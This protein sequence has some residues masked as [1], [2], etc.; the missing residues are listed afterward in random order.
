[1]EDLQAKMFLNRNMVTFEPFLLRKKT[2]MISFT[3]SE[4]K[5]TSRINWDRH[6]VFETR[7]YFYPPAL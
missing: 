3:N 7:V 4:L 5:E 1:M 6:Q 2:D